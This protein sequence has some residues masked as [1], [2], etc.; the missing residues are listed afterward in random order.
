MALLEGPAVQ[1]ERVV[2]AP[3]TPV[4]DAWLHPERLATWWWPDHPAT[5]D[6]VDAR[7]GGSFRI[8]SAETGMSTENPE[9]GWADV[10]SR[11]P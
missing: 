5:V 4:F 11:L 7:E 10:L 9:R 6:E 8:S 2:A 1:V 3:P